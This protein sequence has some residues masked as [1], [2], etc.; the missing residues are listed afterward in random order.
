[1]AS[2][3]LSLVVCQP[4]SGQNVNSLAR[5]HFSSHGPQ[6][7]G[8]AGGGHFDCTCGQAQTVTELLASWGHWLSN[9]SPHRPI[10][11]LSQPSPAPLPHR[12]MDSVCQ[13]NYVRFDSPSCV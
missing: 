8:E 3:I 4:W 1:M 9:L 6:G 7:Q 2:D 11:G 10:P 5:E 13:K 12:T